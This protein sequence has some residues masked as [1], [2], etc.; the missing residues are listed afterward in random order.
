[1]NMLPFVILLEQRKLWDKR[2]ADLRAELE[3]LMNQIKLLSP[4]T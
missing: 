1:M 3:D 2:Q 4:P